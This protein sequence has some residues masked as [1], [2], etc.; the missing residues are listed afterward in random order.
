MGS[1]FGCCRNYCSYR[2]EVSFRYFVLLDLVIAPSAKMLRDFCFKRRY[3]CDE[4]NESEV[5]K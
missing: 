4:G 2:V 5:V 3:S 1:N